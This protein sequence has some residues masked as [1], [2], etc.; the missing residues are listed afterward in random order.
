M[1]DVYEGKSEIKTILIVQTRHLADL[2]VDGRRY[3]NIS[4]QTRR[5]LDL[6]G[7]S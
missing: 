5:G 3:Q 2:N 6:A 7:P 1:Q 4:E